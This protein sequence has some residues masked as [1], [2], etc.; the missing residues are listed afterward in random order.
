MLEKIEPWVLGGHD[1]SKVEKTQFE[2]KSGF[3][4]P[5]QR[6]VW[7]PFQYLFLFGTPWN[8]LQM[9]PEFHGELLWAPWVATLAFF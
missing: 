5:P 9:R 4:S 2:S 1:P 7:Q 8:K 6:P 3:D